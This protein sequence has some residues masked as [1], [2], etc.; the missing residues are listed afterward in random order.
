M[1]AR[2]LSFSVHLRWLV[3]LLTLAAAAF[4]GWSL[5]Q[6]PIDA[7]PDITNNQVQINTIAPALSPVEIE[8]QVTFRSRPRWPAFPGLNT[9]ARCRATAFPRSPP[10]SATSTD[11]YFARQ[12]INRAPDRGRREPAAGRRAAHGAD[13]DRAWRDLHVDGRLSAAGQGGNDRGRQARLAKRRQLSH[14]GGRAARNRTR[15]RG[16]SAHGAGLD[17]SSADAGACRASPASMRSAATS[18]SITCSPTR[19][20]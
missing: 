17:H 2:V 9:R 19:R 8:K 16:L 14:A 15:A 6:L 5:T 11:I 10:S 4:G 13:L 12:Q 7:V 18:S 1:I 3:V 20:S